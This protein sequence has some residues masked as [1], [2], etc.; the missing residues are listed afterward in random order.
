MTKGL[1]VI[2][3]GQADQ[4]GGSSL[5]A[6]GPRVGNSFDLQNSGTVARIRGDNGD[7]QSWIVTLGVIEG[8][9]GYDVLQ[10]RGSAI[11]NGQRC[12]LTWGL[13][14]ARFSAVLD[15]R[16]CSFVVHGSF[17]EVSAQSPVVAF[18]AEFRYIASITPANAVN[19]VTGNKPGGP[20]RTINS[21]SI[22]AMGFVLMSVPARARAVRFYNTSGNAVPNINLQQLTNITDVSTIAV[23]ERISTIGGVGTGGTAGALEISE[24]VPL[25]WCC[26]GLRIENPNNVSSTSVSAEFLI[27]VG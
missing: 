17:V 5:I 4:P 14:S 25:V 13:D 21:G 27:D 23:M 2:L 9:Q 22:A 12:I 11:N 18:N 19:A 1:D 6:F 16:P 15:W 7:A 8:P 24:W 26:R 20:T 10:I 3:E